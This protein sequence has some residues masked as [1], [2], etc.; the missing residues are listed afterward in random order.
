MGKFLLLLG[1]IV[2]AL[3]WWTLGR[4]RDSGTGDRPARRG[5]AN[6]RDAPATMVACAHCGLNLPHSDALFDVGGRPYCS[7]AHRLAGPP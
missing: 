2:V 3:A 1:I 6:R 4:R 7:E 5:G